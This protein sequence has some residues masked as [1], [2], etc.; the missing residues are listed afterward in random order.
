M[1]CEEIDRQTITKTRYW[2]ARAVL[3]E[4]VAGRPALLVL[5]DPDQ[6]VGGT[7]PT[8]LGAG[9]RLFCAFYSVFIQSEILILTTFPE[10]VRFVLD[11]ILGL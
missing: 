2:I 6:E 7:R 10:S 9:G 8:D 4:L 11:E 5:A 3:D 1:P